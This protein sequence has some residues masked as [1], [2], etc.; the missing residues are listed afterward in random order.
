MTSQEL[1]EALFTLDEMVL[2]E[3]LILKL[4]ILSPTPEEEQ[5]LRDNASRINKLT[6]QEQFLFHLIE[7][8]NLKIRLDMILFRL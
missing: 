4:G 7:V 8:P 1:V 3:E 2:T 5:L 6:Q